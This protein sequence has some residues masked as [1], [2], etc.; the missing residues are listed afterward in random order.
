MLALRQNGVLRWASHTRQIDDQ[1]SPQ[2][3]VLLAPMSDQVRTPAHVA[4]DLGAS[5]GRVFLGDL[6]SGVLSLREVHRFSNQPIENGTSSHWD[7]ARLWGEVRAALS[8][9][10]EIPLAGIGV[11]AWGVDYALLGERGELLQNPFH[12]RDSRNL[13]AMAEVLGLVPKDEIYRQTGIQFMPINTLNQLFAAQRD[14]PELLAAARRLIMIPDLFHYWLTGYAVCEFTVASTTQFTNPV[15]RTWAKELLD[16]LGL[17]AQLP[18]NIVEPGSIIGRLLP[19]ISSRTLEGAAIIA[20]ASHDTASAVAAVAARGSTAFLS[21]GTWSLIG[22]ELDAPVVSE[23]AMRMNFTN[24]GGVCGSTRLLKNVMGLWMLQGC[25]ASWAAR[26]QDYSYRELI[27][28][29]EQAAPFRQLVDPD[30][31]SFLN[32]GDMTEAI[33]RFCHKTDQPALEGPAMYVRT[34]LESLALKYRLVIRDLESVTGQ[35]IEC[36]RVIGG[37]SQN[38][39]LN[40]FTADAT[41]KRVV[42]GPAEAAVLGNIGV[43]MLATGG[44][45]SL[46]ETRE[47]IERSF[48]TE[49]FEPK[50]TEEWNREAPRFLQYCEFSY[51]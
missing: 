31:A 12:Y 8:F 20:P 36:I 49:L 41:G 40:Q 16:R 21:S 7:V 38:H 23:P 30:D 35:P 26:G 19:G 51:A 9:V 46:K 28:A 17:P 33:D 14:T 15:T 37:G 29:A 1:S 11:D 34:V 50:N 44:T 18:A 5:N 13:G 43:Q 22:K 39:L 48:P 6:R 24:E 10:D 4:I 45:S 42:A 2:P 32:P 47:I 3:G 27:A 25:R